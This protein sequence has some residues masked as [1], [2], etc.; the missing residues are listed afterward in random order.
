MHLTMAISLLF[1]GIY[2]FGML[3]GASP[4]SL[5][6]LWIHGAARKASSRFP[7]SAGFFHRL[8]FIF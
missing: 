5:L 2:I 1:F 6:L 7:E 4:W 3:K 8:N